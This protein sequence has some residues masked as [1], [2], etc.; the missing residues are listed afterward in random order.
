MQT[1]TRAE[2]EHIL[3]QVKKDALRRCD[4]LVKAYVA[5]CEGKTISVAWK[6]R[7]QLN[8]MNG[9]L[10]LYTTHEDIDRKR[11]EYLQAKAAQGAA[12]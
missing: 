3:K 12:E 2:E 4:E 9:C 7:A 11:T 6:C 5:C 8:E 10:K 1:P